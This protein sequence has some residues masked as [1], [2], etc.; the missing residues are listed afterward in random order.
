MSIAKAVP[1]SIKDRECER[2]T[3]QERPPVPY[4]PEKDPIQELVSLLK[5]DQSLKTTIGADAELRLALRNTR[6]VSLACE[7]SPRHNQ[8]TGHFQGLQGSP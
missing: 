8:E 1:D 2:F 6:G 7:F 5:S 3:L 4:T